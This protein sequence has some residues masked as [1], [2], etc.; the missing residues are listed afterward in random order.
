MLAG[1][2]G[3]GILGL[4]GN[5]LGRVGAGTA[6]VVGAGTVEVEVGAGRIVVVVVVAGIV[7]VEIVVVVSSEVV[8]G[9]ARHQRNC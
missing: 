6:V 2:A 3:A 7:V 4:A 8:V 1:L 5:F 9:A